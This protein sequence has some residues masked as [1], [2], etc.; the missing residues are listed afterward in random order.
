MTFQILSL[1]G[2][3][4]RGLFTAEI[5]ARLEEQADR[6]IG[7]CFDLIAGTSIGGIIAIGLGMGRTAT[8]IR[9]AFLDN[10]EAIFPAQPPPPK[11]WLRSKIAQYRWFTGGPKYDGVQLKRTIESI[12]GAETLFGRAQTRLL[13]P[14]VNMTAGKVQMFKTPHEATLR[15][16][17]HRK[18]VDVALATSA[19][20][21][22]FPLAKI[23]KSY[24]A[25]GGLAANSPDLCA[26]HEAIHFAGQQRADV[27][28]LSIGTTSAKFGLPAS[29][30]GRFGPAEWSANERLVSTVFGVQQQLVDFMMEH[31]YSNQYFRIDTETS[32]E[33]AIDLGLDIADKE[34]RE[35]LQGLA[36]E[37]YQRVCSNPA[38]LKALAHCPEPPEFVKQMAP[39]A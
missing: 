31:E 2:G 39:R 33:H 24:F 8:D 28:I 6:P 35:T 26:V 21:T 38:I 14:A 36:E 25:D 32:A 18:A 1:S 15:V 17:Q 22:F 13:I 7:G 9:D 16:D 11:G 10:G 37:A 4:Y 19:A 20:P 3:G 12:V 27:R 23:G 5:L 30:G 29:L 34:R